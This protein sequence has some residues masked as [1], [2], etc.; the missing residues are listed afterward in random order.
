M[1]KTIDAKK[2]IYGVQ[3][4]LLN[5]DDDDLQ[6][7]LRPA[8][9]GKHRYPIGQLLVPVREQCTGELVFGNSNGASPDGHRSPVIVDDRRW[10]MVVGGG[11]VMVV[12]QHR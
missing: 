1:P 12:A 10:K 6:Q 11:G 4:H 9:A 7:W 5:A 3:F 2:Y 8:N